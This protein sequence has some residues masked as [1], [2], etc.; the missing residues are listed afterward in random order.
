MN[1][2]LNIKIGIF[3][4]LLITSTFAQ[5][6]AESILTTLQQKFRSTNDISAWFVQSINGKVNLKGKFFYKKENNFKLEL[7]NLSIISN[8]ITSWNFNKKENKVIISDYDQSDPSILSLN[9]FIEDYPK[10]CSLKLDNENGKDI[11]VLIPKKSGMSFK[12]VK[13]SVNPDDLIE[14]M[15]IEDLNGSVIQIEFSHYQLDKKLSNSFF[16]FTPPKGS[17]VID[18]R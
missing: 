18:L 11:L 15:S 13:I 1:M 6:D 8:G 17:K 14:R 2:K 12:S 4:L 16:T 5:R 9:K 7:N 10:Q 3:T